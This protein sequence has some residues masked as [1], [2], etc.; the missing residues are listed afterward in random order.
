MSL[1]FWGSVMICQSI[2]VSRNEA[3]I[4]DQE[5]RAREHEF[6]SGHK[7]VD[8]LLARLEVLKAKKQFGFDKQAYDTLI[9]TFYAKAKFLPSWLEPLE[10][11]GKR[12]LY[13]VLVRRL[14][15]GQKRGRTSLKAALAAAVV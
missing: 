4:I 6:N 12:D 3:A 11:A 1:M 5:A 10:K 2:R 8:R 9:D 13:D 15:Q 7:T 14:P